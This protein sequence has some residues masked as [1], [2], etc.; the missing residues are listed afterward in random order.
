MKYRILK[1]SKLEP[2]AKAGTIVYR[3]RFNDYG[4]ADDDE[5]VTGVEHIACTLNENGN[6]P[7]FTVPKPDLDVL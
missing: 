6:Y 5:Y 2:K 3:C 4:C 7:F 1:D